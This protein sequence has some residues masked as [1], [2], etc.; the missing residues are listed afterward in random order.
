MT[1]ADRDKHRVNI[2][3]S[4]LRV[5]AILE[6]CLFF[7]KFQFTFSITHTMSDRRRAEIEAKRAKLAELRK[8]RAD[9]QKADFER[10]QAAEV[11]AFAGKIFNRFTLQ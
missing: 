6:N 9:R 8:A 3:V 1:S 5:D 10:K 11:R 4:S 2:T 7:P